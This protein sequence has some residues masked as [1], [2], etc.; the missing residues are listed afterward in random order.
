MRIAACIGLT[1]RWNLLL[2]VHVHCEVVA[3][4]RARRRWVRCKAVGGEW[5][6]KEV[7]RQELLL[8]TSPHDSISLARHRSDFRKGVEIRFDRFDPPLR[9]VA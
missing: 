2:H 4:L 9:A 1:F 6:E 8:S 5:H 3:L 7:M